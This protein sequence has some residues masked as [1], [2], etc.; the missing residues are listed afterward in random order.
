MTGGTLASIPSPVAPV[1]DRG[2]SP[3]PSRAMLGR[4][5]SMIVHG[6]AGAIDESVRTDHV[7][8]CRR[9]VE[10]AADLLR[11]GGDAVAAACAAVRVLEDDPAFNAGFGSTLDVDG[12]ITTDAAIFR[13]RDLAYGA[14]GAVAGVRHPIDLAEAVLRD[15]QH[16]FLVSHGAIAFARSHGVELCDP[17][18]LE[19]DPSRSRWWF[20]KPDPVPSGSDTVG[21]VVRDSSGDIVAATSTGGLLNKHPGRVGD[22]P[23]AG[24]GTYAKVGMGG[25]SATGHGETIMR[26][27][28]AYEALRNMYGADDPKSAL[29]ASLAEAWRLCGGRGGLIA[30]TADGVPV[31]ARNTK[32]MGVAWVSADTDLDTA[33]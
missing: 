15:D 9:A 23:I 18:S 16:C 22:S 2:S 6:G 26:T 14:I 19:T 8:G 11:A 21:A 3:L 4:M 10:T 27:V 7:S 28:L 12:R 13:G 30:L 31:W 20:T 1:W 32:H 5:W 25:I 17:K 24:A 33:F 29:D